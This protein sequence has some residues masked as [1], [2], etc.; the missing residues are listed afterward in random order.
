[1]L[2]GHDHAYQR[3]AP[4]RPDGTRDDA[5]GIRQIA[6]GTGGGET[7]Y[8]FADPTPAGSNIEVR[9]NHT[10]GVI[11]VTLRSGGYDWKFL[12]ASGATF[13]DSGSGSCHGRP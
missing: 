2:N 11:K 3:F 8:D 1:V 5:H 4:Q 6:V 9:D 10:H 13:T 12:P 7:L